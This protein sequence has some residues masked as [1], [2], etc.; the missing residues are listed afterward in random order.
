MLNSG[1]IDLR[2]LGLRTQLAPYQSYRNPSHSD[3]EMIPDHWKSG[4]LRHFCLFNPSKRESEVQVRAGSIA[5][6]LPMEAV[7][8]AGEIRTTDQRPAS[9]LAEGFTYFRKGDVLLAKIT[10]CFENGK[11]ASLD[12]LPTEI[13]FGSTEFIV[14]RPKKDLDANYLYLLTMTPQFRQRGADYMTGS[15]GQQR[16]PLEF[17]KNYQIPLP[18]S[19][20]QA[21]IV[22]TAKQV[23]FQVS[24]LI[25]NK[26]RLIALLN[27]EKQAII[28]QA[29]T[30]GLDTDAPMKQSGVE[31]LGEIPAHWIVTSLGSI[32][33]LVQTG[34]FGSQL[35]ASDYVEH[36]VP[37]INP[38][39]LVG[40]RI[41]PDSEV[42][43]S[44]ETADRL[45]RHRLRSGDLIAARRG[46]LGRC[47]VVTD[48]ERGW[49]CGT[50][51]LTVR[52]RFDL[53]DPEFLQI[54]FSSKGV[55][56]SLGFSAVGSTMS[57]L[58]A[59]LVARQRIQLPNLS[60]QGNIV[61]H[62][63]NEQEKIERVIARVN[64]EIDLIREYRTRL[65]ADVV[66]GQLDVRGVQFDAAAWSTD[67]HET[68]D[69]D[70]ID[71]DSVNI[72]GTGD[73]FEDE[74]S[75]E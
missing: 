13:G 15:A 64:Q 21:A 49:L 16:I 10:P 39:H 25:R 59:G 43:V 73:L 54:V 40:G 17:V 23:Q 34:P 35:H 58:S 48:Q 61:E 1:P 14:L 26:R 9:E 32:S 51:S 66:T 8:S 67:E 22:R 2:G 42:A 46:E 28:Q 55:G 37:V 69:N 19:E 56:E 44:E 68:F 41:A 33:H 31:W 70:A 60:E 24:R 53:I 11:G 18:P 20:E 50:G 29:V 75:I 7:S 45:S 63:Q 6:F 72:E 4:R 57:N 47:A 12:H 62:L 74:V 71:E 27:E 30:R 5:T 65:I 38:S 3:I 52:P 36:G